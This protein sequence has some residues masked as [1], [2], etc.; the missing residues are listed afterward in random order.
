LI[1][2]SRGTFLTCIWLAIGSVLLFCV[3][4]LPAA[5]PTVQPVTVCEVLSDFNA[6]EGKTVALIGRFSFRSH[7]RWLG[8]E[9]C[10][11]K[12][13]S[14]E[15]TRTGV[16]AIATDPKTAP[17]APPV[18]RIDDISAGQKLQRIKR[19]TALQKF[20]FGSSDYDRWAIIYGRIERKDRKGGAPIQ[21]SIHGDGVIVFLR[22]E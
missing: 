18:L 2:V 21:I 3:S 10:E 4:A 7:G 17:E 8:E 14:G 15:P 6:F 16:I 5:D 9:A 22:D 11:F 1:F 12:P 20:R 19:R 13:S